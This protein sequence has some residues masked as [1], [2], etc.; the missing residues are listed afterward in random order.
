MYATFLFTD[1]VIRTQYYKYFHPKECLI[2][3]GIV[4]RGMGQLL[5]NDATV[6]I[7]QKLVELFYRFLWNIHYVKF[8]S[9]EP[10][11]L[12]TRMELH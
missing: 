7:D 4:N 9:P 6:E 10:V 3:D 1:C 11:C 12:Y 8:I 2:S 5:E